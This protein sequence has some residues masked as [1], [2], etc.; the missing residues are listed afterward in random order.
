M[1]MVLS[2]LLPMMTPAVAEFQNP[3][4]FQQQE[5]QALFDQYVTEYDL[6][7]DLISV[8]YVLADTGE[9]WYHRPDEWF[10]SASLY[11][12]PLMMILAE[13]EADGEL[14]ADS[15]INGMQLSDIE[16]EVLIQSN[17]PVA[18]STMLYVAEPQECRRM[19]QRYAQLKEDDYPWDFYSY[20][21]FSARFMTQVLETLYQNNSWFPHIVECLKQAQPDHYFRLRLGER[22]EIAQKY[23]SYQDEDGRDWNHTA[24]IIYTPRPFILT[25]MTRYGGM[26]EQII[27]DLAERFCDYTLTLQQHTEI[28]GDFQEDKDKPTSANWETEE[29]SSTP[30]AIMAPEKEPDE[31]IPTQDVGPEDTTNEEDPGKDTISEE[32]RF[33]RATL[34]LSGIG[35]TMVLLA[36]MMVRKKRKTR[37]GKLSHRE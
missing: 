26:A 23:G 13:R 4:V 19:F 20:S 28:V 27:A 34:I 37:R 9:S 21:Y 35:L 15:L 22:F 29:V 10:Y 5:I 6:N 11:K 7:A 25:I 2:L 33:P 16:E 32:V 24:G 31:H 8:G 30:V 17:N 36:M 12:V 3:D 18:Y 14:T 1:L